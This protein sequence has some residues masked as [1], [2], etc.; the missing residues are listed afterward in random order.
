[1][2]TTQR[3]NSNWILLAVAAL[4]PVAAQAVDVE[5]AGDVG[6]AASDNIEL[7]ATNKRSDTIASAG[8][9]FSVLEQSRKLSADVVG[10]LAFLDYLRNTYDSQ[11]IGN[12]R[13]S[14]LANFAQDRFGWAVD[15]NFGQTRLDLS[16]P[17]TPVNRENI[18]YFSTGPNVALNLF[19]PE[20]M[21]RLAARYSRVDYQ[22]SPLD[23]VRYSGLLGVERQLS[24]ASSVSIN[25]GDERVEP[26]AQSGIA[27]YDRQE[28]YGRYDLN[29]ALTKLAIDA[30]ITRIDQAGLIN[31]GGLLRL[32][33]SRKLGGL[34]TLTVEAGREF[35][36][37]GSALASN[38]TIAVVSGL[39]SNLL[40][41][42]A[43]PYISKY[44]RLRWEITGHRT[45]IQAS[46]GVD[47]QNFELQAPL[48]RKRY[49]GTLNITRQLATAITARVT[50]NYERDDFESSLS[51]FREATGL[52]GLNWR[53]GRRLFV[54]ASVEDYHYTSQ[55][56][57]GSVNEARIWLRLRYGDATVRKVGQPPAQ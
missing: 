14:A 19:S 44:V 30:G 11:V 38:S 48:D 37:A 7:S 49:I 54:D 41:Q 56:L 8:A 57:A 21:L 28:L 10:D 33:L 52:V 13:A 12:V 18:N 25:A 40:T 17:G 24:S 20:T 2:A 15:D 34:S 51:D 5:M 55:S 29:G 36:D 39:N 22:T 23:S 4:L 6:V 47:E 9:Q 31:S 50:Y 27:N 3:R 32:R 53:V 45:G 35:A 42:T 16:T 1:M 46:A 26:E 43:E